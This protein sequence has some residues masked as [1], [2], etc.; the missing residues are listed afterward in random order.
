MDTVFEAPVLSA[1]YKF[2]TKAKLELMFSLNA[3]IQHFFLD[4]FP[5]PEHSLLLFV[6][7]WY[8]FNLFCDFDTSRS[9]FYINIDDT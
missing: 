9:D 4:I 7:N 6:A 1:T 2:F 8:R 5:E 3:L